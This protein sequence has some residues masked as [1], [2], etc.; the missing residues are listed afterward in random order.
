MCEA[1]FDGSLV[2]DVGDILAEHAKDAAIFQGPQATIRWVGNEDGVAPGDGWNAVM[3]GKKKWGDYTGADSD[4]RGDRWLPMECDARMRATWFWETGNQGTLKTVPQ[5]MEMYEQSVGRG[6]VLLLNNTPDRSGLI[7]EADAGRAA[8]FGREVQRVYGHPMSQRGRGRE[9][10]LRTSSP[11][12]IDRVVI[13]EDVTQGERI[14]T[15]EIETLSHGAWSPRGGGH[16]VGHKRIFK[17]P[18]QVIEGV[19]LRVLDSV[20]EPVIRSVAVCNT[21]RSGPEQPSG[22]PVKEGDSK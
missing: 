21:G 9:V 18:A 19:R 14:R 16:A 17:L 11:T 4:A 10:I 3:S 12:S 20:G 13:M 6:G 8:E 7:P 1:W 15:F 5:L 2:F 22:V